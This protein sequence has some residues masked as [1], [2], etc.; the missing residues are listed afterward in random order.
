MYRSNKGEMTKRWIQPLLKW[1]TLNR[2]V[3]YRILNT[4]ESSNTGIDYKSKRS[5][6]P[7]IDYKK[8][9]IQ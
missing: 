7:G 3:K 6:K 2:R 1:K 9:E 5:S 8:S 4:V